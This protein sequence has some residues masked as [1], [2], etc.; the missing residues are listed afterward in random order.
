MLFGEI[1]TPQDQIPTATQTVSV[2]GNFI[3]VAVNI[4]NTTGHPIFLEKLALS[5]ER[6]LGPEFILTSEETDIPF[7]G[8]VVKRKPYEKSDFVELKTGESQARRIRIDLDYQWLTGK[9]TYKIAHIFLRYI[10]SSEKIESS[11]SEKISF[12]YEL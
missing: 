6:T 2:N 5:R 1:G 7:I 3:Y 4:K 9:H 11:Q 10:P 12:E 8:A